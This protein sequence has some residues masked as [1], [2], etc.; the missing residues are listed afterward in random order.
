[1]LQLSLVCKHLYSVVS[2]SHTLFLPESNNFLQQDS[3]E[4]QKQ[5]VRTS[6]A[7]QALHLSNNM[8]EQPYLSSRFS[9]SANQPSWISHHLHNSHESQVLINPSVS[10]ST[11]TPTAKEAPIYFHNFEQ[12]AT[13]SVMSLHQISTLTSLQQITILLNRFQ[14]LRHLTL[15]K[16]NLLEDKFLSLFK[17]YSST[18]SLIT[19][20]LHHVRIL[21]HHHYTNAREMTSGKQMRRKTSRN[22]DEL[23]FCN[24]QHVSV[25]GT[26][27]Y[28][29]IATLLT[30]MSR[31]L[32]TIEFQGF[33]TISDSYLSS[34]FPQN[35]DIHSH[36]ESKDDDHDAMRYLTKLK[37]KD[38]T[39]LKI[40]SISLSSLLHLDLSHGGI[41]SLNEITCPQLIE[42]N[43]S[44]CSN[45]TDEAIE[46]FLNNGM[47]EKFK[48][49]CEGKGKCPRTLQKLKLN[50]C[51]GLHSLYIQCNSL[52]NLDLSLCSNLKSLE[53]DCA[54]MTD[55]QVGTCLNLQNLILHPTLYLESLDLSL[56]PKLYTLSLRSTPSLSCL[57]LSGCSALTS[58]SIHHVNNEKLKYVNICGTCIRMEDVNTYGQGRCNGDMDDEDEATVTTNWWGNKCVVVDDFGKP[59]S[60][61]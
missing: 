8:S 46:S 23:Y 7:S 58:H 22:K 57:N 32:Q 34:L 36:V 19:L 21:P 52:I 51:R 24:L 59:L 3:Y 14:N 17:K 53:V 35:D 48:N 2:F 13:T 18:P 6:M 9:N 5:I 25:T 39:A 50:G 27:F 26:I 38:F 41:C 45:L 42:L 11:S 61:W 28:A 54:Y 60:F 43:L 40:P 47:S 31:K 15:H 4:A 1:M 37:C 16:L 29:E 33:R 55:F 20:R 56:L 10:T 49:S 12:A 44:F 30:F